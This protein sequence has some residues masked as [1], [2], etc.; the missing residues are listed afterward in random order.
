MMLKESQRMNA[1]VR[2]RIFDLIRSNPQ[3]SGYSVTGLLDHGWTGEGLW[4]LWR[5]FKPEV[6]DAVCDGWAP[7]RFCLFAKNHVFSGEKFE[8]EA[9]LANECVLPAGSYVADFAITSEEGTIE[10]WSEPFEIQDDAFAVPVMKKT[11][12]LDQKSG[13]YSLIAYLKGASPLGNKLDFYL[14]SK[15]D[16]HTDAEVV[17][18]G[19]QDTTVQFLKSI[20]ATL[21]TFTGEEKSLILAGGQVTEND[22]KALRQA[23][24]NGARVW[25]INYEAFWGEN[26]DHL[27]LLHIAE[28]LRLKENMEWLYHKESVLADNK[29]FHGL[30]HGLLDQK[31]FGQVVTNKCFET[32]IVPDEVICP[33][34]YTGYHGYPGGYACVHNAFGVKC[35]EGS[36][37][38]MTFE[39]EKNLEKE[40]AAGV[41]LR[42]LAEK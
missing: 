10:M 3:Y 35:G 5:R 9:V 34:F 32:G 12:S 38:L 14:T 20:G 7:L 19:L 37:Y 21:K 29:I 26:K 13:K 28:D 23:A 42:N 8:M 2:R 22:I 25:F 36:I 6:Y 30:G 18:C 31:R 15:E 16:L 33:A 11:I 41:M 27:K 4:S 24:E 17:V 40:P 1:E 39:L